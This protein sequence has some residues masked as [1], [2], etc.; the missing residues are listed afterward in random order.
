MGW[1]LAAN[2]LA[3]ILR[4]PGTAVRVTLAPF[5]LAAVLSVII[6][7]FLGVG[8]DTV[9]FALAFGS[10]DGRVA[11]ALASATVIVIF[12]AS[13]SALAWHRFL[14]TGEVP[15][16]LPAFDWNRTGSYA[17]R[18]T[19]ITL[20]LLILLFPIS[21]VGMQVLTISGLLGIDL[22]RLGFSFLMT[23]LMAFL[24]FRL[25]L[26]LPAVAVERSLTVSE[27]WSV[28]GARAEVIL[29]AG[30]IIVALDLVAGALLD[31]APLG[32]WPVLV[33][34]LLLTWFFALAGTSLVTMLYAELVERRRL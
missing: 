7:W 20:S 18:S 22:V 30:A 8:I 14:L 19:L 29:R 3:T 31:F 1:K 23:G 4:N 27:S 21:A 16:A 25:A 28:T 11:S 34:R 26:V 24:W 33:L 6:W 5:A 9:T 32:Q 10:I 13:W 17:L 12:V 15:G 2:S